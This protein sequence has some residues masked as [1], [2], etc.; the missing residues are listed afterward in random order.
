MEE[1]TLDS[2]NGRSL[3][4]R[5][6][7][8][9]DSERIWRFVA[10][11]SSPKGAVTTKVLD[12][13]PG[14]AAFVREVA[15]EWSGFVGLKEYATLEGQLLLSCRHDGKGAVYCSATLRQPEPPEWSLEAELQFGAGAHLE[16]L[17]DDVEAFSP[18]T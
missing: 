12:L 17:A 16:K 13:G 3:T 2:I 8:A 9:L 15:V 6:D 11:L 18:F 4:L 1:V 7:L 14:L 10:T 5:R